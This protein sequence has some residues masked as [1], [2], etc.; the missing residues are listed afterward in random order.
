[1]ISLIPSNSPSMTRFGLRPCASSGWHGA[2][3]SLGGSHADPRP[4]ISKPTRHL[5][6]GPMP[7]QEA[8]STEAELC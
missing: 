6:S 3:S 8:Q 7:S 4:V 5:S 1:M 2:E